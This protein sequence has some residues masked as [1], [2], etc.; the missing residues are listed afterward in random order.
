M[1]KAQDALKT[2]KINIYKTLPTP[3]INL[4]IENR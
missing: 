2:V 3:H 4:T 1:P